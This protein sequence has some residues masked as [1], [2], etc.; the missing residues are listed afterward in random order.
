MKIDI[1]EDCSI[2]CRRK[3]FII[4]LT[5]AFGQLPMNKYELF[6]WVERNI[7]F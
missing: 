4:R 3:F 6:L 2:I 1:L 5:S 7:F